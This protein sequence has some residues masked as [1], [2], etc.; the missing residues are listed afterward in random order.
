MNH[1]EAAD[2]IVRDHTRA[3][4][5]HFVRCKEPG[6]I[7]MHARWKLNSQFRPYILA[8]EGSE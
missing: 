8:A 2:E 7:A 1:C 6:C 3:C 5:E 4:A